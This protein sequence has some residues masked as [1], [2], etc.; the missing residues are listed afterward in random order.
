MVNIDK[1]IYIQCVPCG[2]RHLVIHCPCAQHIPT[3]PELPDTYSHGCGEPRYLYLSDK[4][5]LDVE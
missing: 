2:N 3:H 5:G 4:Y 1:D